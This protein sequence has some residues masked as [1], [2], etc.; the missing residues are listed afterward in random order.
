M[1]TSIIKLTNKPEN[2]NYLI[3]ILLKIRI[4]SKKYERGTWVNS[5]LNQNIND[6]CKE[7][8]KEKRPDWLKMFD[9]WTNDKK[10]PMIQV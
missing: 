3:S 8:E 2:T 10:C 1:C 5:M 9:E 7:M 6:I 4:M